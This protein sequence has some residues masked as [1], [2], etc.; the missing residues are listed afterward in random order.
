M[1][2]FRSEE[3]VRKWSDFDAT[4]EKSIKPVGEW[5][6]MVTGANLV[7]CRLDDDFVAKSEAYG[8]E[9]LAGLSAALG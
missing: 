8:N 9:L 3:S 2:F 4:T 1:S 6:V 5:A 7:R